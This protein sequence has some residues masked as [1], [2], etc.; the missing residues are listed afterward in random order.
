MEYL[1]SLSPSWRNVVGVLVIYYI[2]LVFYRLFL[3]PLARFPG[4]KLAAISRWYEAYYDLIQGGQYTPKIM[5]MHKQ[6]GPIIRISPYELHVIDP[7]FFE[8]LYR[9][10]GNL[11][12]PAWN[13]D[14]FNVWR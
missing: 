7:A 6:Y 1:R 5:E 14:A 9:Q 8:T 11:D 4:P 12:K 3:H 10:D 2:T 13:Y